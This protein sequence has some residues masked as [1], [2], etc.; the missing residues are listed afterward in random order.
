[1]S[2]GNTINIPYDY[3]S[4][5]EGIDAASD[6]DTVLVHPGT[7]YGSIDFDRK[8]L[9]VGSLFLL[10][11]NESFISQTIIIQILMYLLLYK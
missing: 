6:G 8:N 4:I 11:A 2:F 1:M 10:D 3:S 7:Y 9:V 5:Q